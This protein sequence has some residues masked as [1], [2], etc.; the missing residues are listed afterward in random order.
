[1]N[2]SMNTPSLYEK[3]SSAKPIPTAYSYS[4]TQ[5]EII[6]KYVLEF[7]KSLDTEHDIGLLLTNFG[8]S[9]LMR[10]SEDLLNEIRFIS[11][12]EEAF[13]AEFI[14]K[15]GSTFKREGSTF[16]SLL[17]EIRSEIPSVLTYAIDRCLDAEIDSALK[18]K[19]KSGQE[20]RIMNWVNKI[21]SFDRVPLETLNYIES[22]PALD[23][24]REP[25]V[26]VICR[27]CFNEFRV[28]PHAYR[29]YV[30]YCPKCDQK[31]RVNTSKREQ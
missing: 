9:I 1:M 28:R 21:R 5:F 14:K 19:T 27:S 24:L 17:E 15:C 30:V 25:A 8:S 16:S 3:F 29:N 10:R 22:L 20:K 2:F 18:L 26:T 7:Q 11:S 13:G 31:L 12:Y 6:R 23:A 4:D